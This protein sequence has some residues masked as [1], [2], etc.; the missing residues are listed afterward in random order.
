LSVKL[1]NKT[2]Q[3]QNKKSLMDKSENGTFYVEQSN[4]P[5]LKI[6]KQNRG[7]LWITFFPY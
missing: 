3:K 4:I 6:C 7:G 1:E 5:S 2:K